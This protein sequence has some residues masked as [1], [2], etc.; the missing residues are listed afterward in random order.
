MTVMAPPRWKLDKLREEEELAWRTY[1][2]D[3]QACPE[4]SYEE[5]EP[6]AWVLLCA[7]LLRIERERHQ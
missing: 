2:Q 3:T 5:V 7:K 1:L 6:H 4:V